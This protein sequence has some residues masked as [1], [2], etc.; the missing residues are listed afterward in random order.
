MWSL[1]LASTLVLASVVSA[2]FVLDYPTARG[3]DE[4]TLVN[5]PC[6][7]QNSV[8]S[9]RTTVSTDGFAIELTMGHDEAAVEVLLGLGN[10]PGESFNIVLKQTFR[11]EGLGSFCLSDVTLPSSLNL[12]DGQ[13]AT[14]Q[15][16]T[17]GDPDGG[18]YNCADITFSTATTESVP[19]T[20]KNG[21]G[22]TAVAFSG[23]AAIRNANESTAEGESQSGSSS[24]SSTSAAATSSPTSNPAAVM[25][26]SWG[27]LG[28]AV[29]GAVAAL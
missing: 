25:A 13:N 15:V 20:C 16:I 8:S 18:L 1:S 11:E 7:G 29:I 6:G 23:T 5:F 26:V 27:F 14:L 24:P 10:D 28:A 12:T 4:D 9:N 2:H 3:F 21:T 17:N 22:V 19:S